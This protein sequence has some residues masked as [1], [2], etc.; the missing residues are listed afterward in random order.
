MVINCVFQYSMKNIF[1]EI[2]VIKILLHY[3]DLERDM[4]DQAL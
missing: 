3:H 4:W 1:N 2:A